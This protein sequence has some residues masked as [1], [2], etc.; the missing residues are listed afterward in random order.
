MN[1][2]DIEKRLN[3]LKN[4]K[5][6]KITTVE[7]SDFTVPFENIINQKE[8]EALFVKRKSFY[9]TDYFFFYFSI[10]SINPIV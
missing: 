2:L 6:V 4:C 5:M 1:K 3:E 10:A 7:G 8:K 9:D